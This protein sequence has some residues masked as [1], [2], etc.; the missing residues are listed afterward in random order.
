MALRVPFPKAQ[1]NPKMALQMQIAACGSISVQG[2]AICRQRRKAWILENR[3]LHVDFKALK[4]LGGFRGAG[5]RGV[6]S[7]TCLS[8]QAA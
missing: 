8:K 6:D 4:L 5:L 2:K 7:F 3:L 1:A